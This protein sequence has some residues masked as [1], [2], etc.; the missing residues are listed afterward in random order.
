[1]MLSAR[2][3][4]DGLLKALALLTSPVFGSLSVAASLGGASSEQWRIIETFTYR[5]I[6]DEIAER[7]LSLD[8]LKTACSDV[9]VVDSPVTHWMFEYDPR[10]RCPLCCRPHFVDPRDGSTRSCGRN[11][12]TFYPP[13]WRWT[14]AT[15][16]AAVEGTYWPNHRP[17]GGEQQPNRPA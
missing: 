13:E 11:Q 17:R 14:K 2:V 16:M 3:S 15:A 4:D 10:P 5:M 9:L 8:G 6:A 7:G 12:R 1:M